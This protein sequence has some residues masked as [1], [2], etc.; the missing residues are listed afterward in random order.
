M[1]WPQASTRRFLVPWDAGDHNSWVCLAL[2]EDHNCWVMFG[3]NAHVRGITL[4]FGQTLSGANLPPLSTKKLHVSF[5]AGIS[6]IL[7]LKY[8]CS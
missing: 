3:S 1:W 5:L 8:N 2:E 6:T 7:Y 4:S